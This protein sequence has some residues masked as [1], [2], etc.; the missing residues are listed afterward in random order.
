MLRQQIRSRF[1][2]R[3]ECSLRF[4]PVFITDGHVFI[5]NCGESCKGVIHPLMC[6]DDLN[7]DRPTVDGEGA[8]E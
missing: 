4:D 2:E 8:R 5:E 6:L 7:E 3:E 1:V